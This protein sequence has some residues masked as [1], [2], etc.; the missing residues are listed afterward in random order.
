[1]QSPVSYR[2]RVITEDDLVFIRKLITE[3]CYRAANWT[4]LGQTTGRG[5]DDL[6]HKANRSIKDVLGYPLVK[7]FRKRLSQLAA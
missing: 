4:V 6:A 5:K 3:H 2:H 1:M 7:D